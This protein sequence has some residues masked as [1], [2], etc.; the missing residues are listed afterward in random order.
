MR[1]L[2]Q[3]TKEAKIM[4]RRTLRIRRWLTVA[5]AV[6]ALSLVSSASAM[7]PTDNAGGSGSAVGG[8]AS[9]GFDWS[10][11]AIG[12]LIA[13]ALVGAGVAALRLANN[14]RRLAELPR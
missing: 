11:P 8:T 7:V 2:T 5:V 4:R 13:L 1:Q 10:Y 9:G 6:A 14:R 12:A 3:D